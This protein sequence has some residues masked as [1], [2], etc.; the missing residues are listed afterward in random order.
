MSAAV[1]AILEGMPDPRDLR[2]HEHGG[3]CV[4]MAGSTVLYEYAA[5]DVVMRNMALCGLRQ[6]G[7]RGRAVAA[8]L[9]LSDAYVAT[10]AAAVAVRGGDARRRPGDLRRV[11]R[12]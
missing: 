1:A 5:S 4:I 3:R 7:F 12:R 2:L 9:G 8:V 10:A 11:L 6:L